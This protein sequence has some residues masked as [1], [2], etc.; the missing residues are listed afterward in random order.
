MDTQ[1]NQEHQ[2]NEDN[3][4]ELKQRLIGAVVVTALAAIFVPMLFDEPVE[5]N[6]NQQTSELAV[7]KAPNSIDQHVQQQFPDNFGQA[8]TPER[9]TINANGTT[10]PTANESAESS[11][12]T[13]EE[14]PADNAVLTEDLIA[15]ESEDKTTSSKPVKT[16]PSEPTETTELSKPSNDS[17]AD[18]E[19][20]EPKKTVHESPKTNAAALQPT[21]KKKPKNTETAAKESKTESEQAKPKKTA[22]KSGELGS[23]TIQA[24]SFSKKEN[25]DAMVAKLKKQGFPVSLQQSKNG[26]YRLKVGSALDKKQ[27]AD[28]KRK[29]DGQGIQSLLMAE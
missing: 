6:S 9:S 12:E 28:M 21:V 11:N 23:W 2:E 25:A 24:G 17:T 5:N 15:T 10:P 19:E 22:D 4:S 27:A 7:P 16:E 26:L 18:Q 29:L 3:K 13:K 20:D 1:E 14:V 8:L